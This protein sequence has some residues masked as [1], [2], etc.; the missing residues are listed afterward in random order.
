MVGTISGP[1]SHQHRWLF[2]LFWATNRRKRRICCHGSSQ[3]DLGPS[4]GD[5]MTSAA[6][7]R[8]ADGTTHAQFGGGLG[9]GV[10]FWFWGVFVHGCSFS[11]FILVTISILISS[12]WLTLLLPSFQPQISHNTKS[13]NNNRIESNLI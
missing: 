8:R 11:L 13:S 5:H 9:L 12:L 3:R 6:A 10:R 2:L 1:V 4:L 7:G